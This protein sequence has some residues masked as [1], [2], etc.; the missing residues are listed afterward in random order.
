MGLQKYRA[1][2]K[3][4]TQTTGA[5]PFYTKWIGGPSLALI[6]NCPIKNYPLDIPPRTVYVRGE[7][8]SWFTQPAACVYKRKTITG[9][10]TADD[11]GN[12]EFRCY[13][14]QGI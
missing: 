8:D 12:Y 9:Y 11:N 4:E 5:I 13:N 10:I 14:N 3:G 2:I 6:R 7:P 1:D